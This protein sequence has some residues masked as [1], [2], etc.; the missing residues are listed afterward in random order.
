MQ[1]WFGM[2]E[3][4]GVDYSH[5]KSLETTAKDTSRAMPERQKAMKELSVCRKEAEKK[6]LDS[7]K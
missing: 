6:F 2:G 1:I 7:Q 5:C 3:S 4:A